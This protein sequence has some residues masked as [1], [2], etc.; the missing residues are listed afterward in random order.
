LKVL[1]II[2][3]KNEGSSFIFSRRQVSRLKEMGVEGDTYFLSSRTNVFSLIRSAKE[4]KKMLKE[5][6]PDLVHAHYGS[7]NGFFALRLGH[8]RTIITFHGSDLNDSSSVGFLRKILS[9]KA[10]RYCLK[11]SACNIVV[12][13]D[14]KKNVPE[15]YNHKTVVIPM[16]VDE[17]VFK[18][19]A[20]DDA[21][22]QLGWN[23]EEK[24][25]L[26]NANDPVVKRLDIALESI[27][28]VKKTLPLARLEVL[29]GN[30]DPEK[31]P[32]LL[33]ASDVLLLCSDHE[34]SPMMIKEA[35][36][37][38]LP[39]VSTV[40]GDTKQR[41]EHVNGAILTEQNP[42]DIAENL[43]KILE[44][45]KREAYNLRERFVSQNL[46]ESGICSEIMNLYEK[47]VSNSPL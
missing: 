43:I 14:L 44:E 16:G 36:A 9:N 10:S 42:V 25:V 29:K 47:I 7:V 24:V 12:N 37:C 17:H 21:R 33:N 27:E 15:K 4:V 11:N 46:S 2:P 5:I 28:K 19:L 22:E 34:G 18:P 40:V 30:V 1:W 32:L 26:F 45:N 35:M 41:L 3:G 39:I 38:N 20:R 13:E 23:K 31:I 8:P 6:K